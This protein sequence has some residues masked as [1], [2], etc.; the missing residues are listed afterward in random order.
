MTDTGDARYQTCKVCGAKDCDCTMGDWVTRLQAEN[1]AL[2]AELKAINAALDDPRIDLTMTA[3]EVIAALKEQV[4][5][6][7]DQVQKNSIHS[8]L[9]DAW[10]NEHGSQMPWGKLI[11]L[12][13][14]L[15]K[16]PKEEED[17]LLYLDYPDYPAQLTTLQS[18][19]A[20]LVDALEDC[21]VEINLH[22]T[23]AYCQ[24]CDEITEDALIKA[25]KALA[26]FKGEK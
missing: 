12:T 20:A 13:A 6:L 9:V 16:L 17:R 1:A 22:K 7:E 18:K 14:V 25:R 8:N 26:A 2:K 11:R 15:E 4:A 23:S 21:E 24:I 19:S 10:C 3:C 5:Q